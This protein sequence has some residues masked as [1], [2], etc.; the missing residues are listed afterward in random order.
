[1]GAHQR[2]K[3][4]IQTDARFAVNR[5]KLAIAP[6]IALARSDLF[7]AQRFFDARVIV[8]YLQRA[9]TIL[10]DMQRFFLILLAAFPALKS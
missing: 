10:A 5:Q 2:R 3:A 7:P 6:Q 8:M 4:R 1:M 9:K